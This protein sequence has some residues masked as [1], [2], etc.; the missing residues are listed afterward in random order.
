M[1]RSTARDG[2][3]VRQ[4]Y[5]G[6]IVVALAMLV[7]ICVTGFTF[8]AFGV[9]VLPVSKELMLSRADINTALVLKNLGNAIW[10]PLVGRLLDKV[11]AKPVMIICSILFAVSFFVLA[12]SHWLWLS[13][14][15]I[16]VGI[17]IAYLG[18]GSLSNTLLVARWFKVQRGRAMMLAGIGTS[19]GTMIAAPTA[20]Y[21][22]E[23]YGWRE[24]LKI[25]GVAIGGILL[26]I[27]VVIRERPGPHDVEVRDAPNT[28]PAP[29]PR[30]ESALPPISMTRLLRT[31][32]FW[33]MC[34]STSMGFAASQ[35]VVISFVPLGR[36]A[37]LSMLQATSLV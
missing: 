25:L 13:A 36:E 8:G 34:L 15:V 7:Y 33:T 5:Y 26:L 24:A 9:F 21:L 11:R 3:R 6:W 12:L 32:L 1:T 27:A 28:A 17:P 2:K 20:G 22:V 29:L 23:A 14:L 16:G 35:A 19:L 4:V 30:A 31:P 10:A 37:G 18:A